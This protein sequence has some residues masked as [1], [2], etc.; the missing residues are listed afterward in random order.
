M[1]GLADRLQVRPNGCRIE[2]GTV[3]RNHAAAT[4]VSIRRNGRTAWFHACAA[5]VLSEWSMRFRPRPC[6]RRSRSHAMA[7]ASLLAV[8]IVPDHADA[9]AF[10][11]GDTDVGNG[12][13]LKAESVRLRSGDDVAWTRPALEAGWGFADH[14]ELAVGSGY[15]VA[16]FRDGRRHHGSHDLRLALKW[17]L[18]Q[19]SATSMG[20][21]LEP[22]LILPTGDRDAGIGG[23]D[24]LLALPLR[25]SR[26][27]GRGRLTGQVAWLHAS[28]AGES[29][30]SAG[31][32]YEYEVARNLWLGAEAL[33]DAAMGDDGQVSQRGSLGFRWQSQGAWMLFGGYGRS[34]RHGGD[35]TQTSVRMGIEYVFQ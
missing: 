4:G 20:L 2:A 33:H 5:V 9:S 19:E 10:E 14:F 11:V 17:R 13:K 28:R 25:V 6:M 24:T 30:W 35:G 34:W 29:A 22:E 3:S 27:F 7:I 31:A 23:D 15:G 8:S 18:R 32:L 16:E 12:L 21:A 26:S 1:S